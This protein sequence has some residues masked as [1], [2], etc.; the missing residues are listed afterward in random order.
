MARRR[1]VA[2]ASSADVGS[3]RRS[4]RGF[5]MRALAIST[6][7]R[8]A[9][10]RSRTIAPEVDR[11]AQLIEDRLRERAHPL[12]VDERAAH[13]LPHGEQVAEHVQ[14]GEQAQLLGDHRDAVANGV[15]G[16]RE[17]HLRT[18][19]AQGPGIGADGTRHDLDE[20]RLAG[21]VLAEQGVD[22]PRPDHHGGVIERDDPAVGLPDSLCLERV[23]RW[24]PATCSTGPGWRSARRRWGPTRRPSRRRRP[25]G[26]RSRRCCPC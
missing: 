15:G 26:R 6:S 22:R 25:G 8:S 13:R 23:H 11:Q 2:P 12:P 24:S 19:E 7:W 21:P 10:V 4:T 1:S 14:V 5:G 20:R 9:S 16:G 18:V 17:L 3:S